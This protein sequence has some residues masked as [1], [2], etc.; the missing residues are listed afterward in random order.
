MTGLV[1]HT[2]RVLQ[3]VG[4]C[5]EPMP[6]GWLNLPPEPLVEMTVSS[7]RV[8]YAGLKA[9]CGARYQADLIGTMYFAHV[10]R[11]RC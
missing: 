4:G 2:K 6:S 10:L 5:C 7:V 11:E 1:G 9:F 8:Y 3:R